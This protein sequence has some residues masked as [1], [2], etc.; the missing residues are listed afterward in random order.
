MRKVTLY[1]KYTP[2]AGEFN[3]GQKL[4]ETAG[5]LST[6]QQYQALLS[7]G[8]QLD[9]FRKQRYDLNAQLQQEAG[10]PA[11]D[12]YSDRVDVYQETVK[13]ANKVAKAKRERTQ[14]ANQTVD[15]DNSIRSESKATSGETGTVSHP[16]SGGQ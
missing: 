4:V 6:A 8:K 11:F 9:A 10:I 16:P 1:W 5:I 12:K 7:A 2:S 13:L 14:K 15:E 3:K